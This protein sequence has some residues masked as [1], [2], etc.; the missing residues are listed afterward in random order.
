M[1]R[2]FG[3]GVLVVAV[4]LHCHV[5]LSADPIEKTSYGRACLRIEGRTQPPTDPLASIDKLEPALAKA[6]VQA[7]WIQVVDDGGCPLV[8]NPYLPCRCSSEV[9]AAN[10]KLLKHW[11]DEIR[12][13]GMSAVS[14]I[15]LSYCA[16]GGA[17]HP[18]W[19]QVSILPWPEECDPNAACCVMSPYGD[20]LIAYCNWAI[21]HFKLDGVWFDGSFWTPVWQRPLPLTCRC[22]ACQKKF[23]E[24]TGAQIPDHVDWS[25]PVFRQWLAWRY[26]AFGDYLGRLSGAIRKAHPQ[27]IVAVNHYHRCDSPWYSGVPLDKYAADMI[28]GSESYTALTIDQTMRLCRAYG[29]PQSEVWRQFDVGPNV[30]TGVEHLLEHALVCYTA[31]GEASFGY[32]TFTGEDENAV[33][34]A[35]LMTPILDTI[36]P[37]VG[38]PSLPYCAVHVS[39]QTETFFFGPTQ[40][41]S[42]EPNP[43]FGT[44]S[45]WTEG[46]GRAHLSPDYVFDADFTPDFLARYKLLLMPLSIAISDAQA[47]TAIEYVRSGGT[48]LLGPGAGQCDPEGQRRA[49]NPLAGAFGFSFEKVVPSVA[50]RRD[51]VLIADIAGRQTTLYADRRTK[52][53]L[54]ASE[55]RVLGREGADSDAPPAVAIRPFGRGRVVVMS[56]DGA[57]LLGSMPV[58]GG[59]TNMEVVAEA[60]ASGKQCLKCTD[61]GSAPESYCPD[62]ETCVAPFDASDSAGGVVQ[63]D[64][65]IDHSAAVIV[66]VR[67]DTGPAAGP[68]LMIEPE[69]R[70]VFGGHELGRIPVGQWVHATIAYD[71]AREGRPS[72]CRAAVMLPDGKKLE[73][74]STATPAAEYQRTDRV[75]IFGPGT[76]P[77]VFYLDNIEVSARKH[78]GSEVAVC[79]EG[80][81]SGPDALVLPQQFVLRVAGLLSEVAPPPITLQTSPDVRA[82]I[83]EA[84]G[85]RIDVHLHNR[86]ARHTDWQQP[87]GPGAVLRGNLPV[88][89][90]RSV[91]TARPLE[92]HRQADSWEIRVPAIGL[93]EVI[94]LEKQ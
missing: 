74:P 22:L 57:D 62:L 60:P 64:L 27:A 93:Y 52:L 70:V 75:V 69:G 36:H 33:A 14:W 16:S 77:A 48:L 17:E 38:G 4:V 44:L 41:R 7:R 71:F 80:F 73:S 25:N 63:F 85:N 23:T 49:E 67:S 30:D 68:R 83:F 84:E 12:R 18:D 2:S 29:R 86:V 87:T 45:N 3:F 43:F 54:A 1:F 20:A 39:Q 6:G 94:V 28:T 51:I 32:D 82:G 92:I 47:R 56:V 34:A 90:A 89:Q 81:E 53:R 19:R 40:G 5:L 91:V 26:R 72:T 61:A 42:W 24:A 9:A 46:L 58:H 88:R 21:E 37:Y 76:E 50:D 10:E 55:W 35:A 78:D 31:G 79:R 15:S 11:V 8:E 59:D 13:S 66:D 65:R